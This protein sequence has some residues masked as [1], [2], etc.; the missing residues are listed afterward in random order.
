M[1]INI[2]LQISSSVG[3]VIFNDP[4]TTARDEAKKLTEAGIDIV[5]VLSHCGLKVDE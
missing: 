4:L 1:L 2:L 3:E 5:I